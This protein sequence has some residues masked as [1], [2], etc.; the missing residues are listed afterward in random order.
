LIHIEREASSDIKGPIGRSAY[1]ISSTV[2]A[3]SGGTDT[4]GFFVGSFSAGAVPHPV[5]RL[6]AITNM[7]ATRMKEIDF[8]ERI[9]LIMA[10]LSFIHFT[11]E[12][13]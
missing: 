12:T 5:D 2:S 13:L 11:D 7:S 1:R 3:L 9:A 10:V 4:W 6:S 8:R